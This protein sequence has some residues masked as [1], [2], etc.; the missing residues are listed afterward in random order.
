[1]DL[2]SGVSGE[3]GV[4]KPG[5]F[6]GLQGSVA[7]TA[8]SGVHACFPVSGSDVWRVQELSETLSAVLTDPPSE[9]AVDGECQHYKYFINVL[10]K[11]M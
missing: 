6:G 9:T 3:S 8:D 4:Q 7:V 1:M 11:T 5:S 10:Y 2:R